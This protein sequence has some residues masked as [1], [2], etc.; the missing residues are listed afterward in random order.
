MVSSQ[1]LSAST[2]SASP[3]VVLSVANSGS[4]SLT[5]SLHIYP[6]FNTAVSSAPSPSPLV[7]QPQLQQFL[8]MTS[9]PLFSSLVNSAQPFVQLSMIL[10]TPDALINQLP[11]QP[12]NISQASSLQISTP[13]F[14]A[15]ISHQ[16]TAF[17]I[18]QQIQRFGILA[19][20][21]QPLMPT[22]YT[23]LLQHSPTA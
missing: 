23:Q 12:C 5:F 18:Q 17:S 20:P 15:T 10:L 22:V 16:V 9:L 8:Q 1:K 19:F 11:R 7:S 2:M 4:L 14:T 13:T 6:A 21:S 3:R